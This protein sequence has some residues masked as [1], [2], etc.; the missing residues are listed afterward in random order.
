MM[1]YSEKP[2]LQTVGKEFE[3]KGHAPGMEGS[4]EEM[5]LN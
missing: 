4:N 1:L 3:R 2:V 5:L